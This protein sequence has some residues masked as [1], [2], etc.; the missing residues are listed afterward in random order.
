MLPLLYNQCY[1]ST[2]SSLQKFTAHLHSS[3]QRWD[4]IRRIKYSTPGRWVSSLSLCRLDV[5]TRKETYRADELLTTL[6]P[7]LPFLTRLELSLS[8]QLSRRA[9][10]S[11]GVREGA[12]HLRALKSVKYDSVGFVSMA[13]AEGGIAYEDPLTELVACLHG[14]EELEIIGPGLDDLELAIASST[15]DHQND[16]VFSSPP[17]SPLHLPHLHTLT[18]LSMPTSDLLIHLTNTPLPS[19]R[20][21]IITPYGT[22]SPPLSHVTRFLKA[23]GPSIRTLVLHTPPAWPTAVYPPPSGLLEMM[24]RLK[25]L[26]LELPPPPPQSTSTLTASFWS[27]PPTQPSNPHPL[28]SLWIPRPTATFRTALVTER[29]LPP[30]TCLMEV[31]ARDV[32]WARKGMNAQ[33][34]AAGVQG[35]MRVWQRLLKTKSVLMV[36]AEGRVEAL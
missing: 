15:S 23:H 36:D 35:E 34:E 31:R 1:I 28:R 8:M 25:A 18:I 24:P 30:Y 2:L 5:V 33:A 12:R 9:M 19:L 14:L 6:F 22:L 10:C 7:L 26:S 3:E 21:V 11:L 29:L 27:Q 4:S 16:R 13:L 20:N 32:R 17:S